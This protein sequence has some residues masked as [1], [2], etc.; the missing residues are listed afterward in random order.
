MR[1]TIFYIFLLIAGYL[2]LV[3]FTGFSK[4]LSTTFS[5]ATGTITALQGR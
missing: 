3:H 5:G 4:D 2:A 1:K